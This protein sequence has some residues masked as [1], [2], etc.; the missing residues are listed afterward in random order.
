MGR[1]FFPDLNL[2]CSKAQM[3]RHAQPP[4]YRWMAERA[5]AARP[6]PREKMGIH[7]HVWGPAV[8]TSY[9]LAVLGSL[10]AGE[11]RN[12]TSSC[13]LMANSASLAIALFVLYFLFQSA[14]VAIDQRRHAESPREQTLWMLAASLAL[15]G[16]G[17]WWV[18]GPHTSGL[19]TGSLTS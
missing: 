16:C 14:A 12:P 1:T 11:P 13:R 9:C 17:I 10:T 3:R 18:V 5:P 19:L 15:G 8:F 2:W 4:L 6:R 7:E